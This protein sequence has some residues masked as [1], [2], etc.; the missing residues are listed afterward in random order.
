MR[1]EI[2]SYLSTI[3]SEMYELT[4]FLYDNPEDSFKEKKAQDYISKLL[5]NKGFKVSK[6][7]MDIPTAFHA[8][9]GEGHPKIC[10]ICEY[11]GDIRKGHIYGNNLSTSISIG[12]ALSL[13]KVI[14]KIRG[15]VI[16]I[17]TPGELNGGSKITMFKQGS[18][19]DI[20]AILIS[21]PY[22]YNI[23]NPKCPAILP[24]KIVFEDKLENS[25]TSMDAYIMTI[26]LL[27]QLAKGFKPGSSIESFS[28]SDKG[29]IISLKAP[30]I[31]IVAEIRHQIEILTNTLSELIGFNHEVTLA[32][33]PC[34]EIK[35]SQTFNR[36]FAH[37]LKE[38][39]IIELETSKYVS[40]GSSLGCISNTI[41]C[42][43]SFISIVRDKTITYPSPE[44]AKE[45]L[46][47]YALEIALK[48]TQALAF[49]G[50]DLIE[51]QSLL[52]EA[53]SELISHN[54]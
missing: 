22:L 44:F 35:A 15:S 54:S 25:L 21:K 26:N 29:C 49:T 11:D 53:K 23:E 46:S 13:A 47:D 17:G 40:M 32:E 50:L 24:L 45:T 6:N 28:V 5:L 34:A 12:S 10:F 16:I 42:I 19:E 31:D 8:Q 39:G 2:T 18:F 33:L 43:N 7:Y 9:I 36:L 51:K 1:Q 37:N 27:C 48:A 41:P 52:K 38:C 30:C 3:K 4:K 20:D 14:S